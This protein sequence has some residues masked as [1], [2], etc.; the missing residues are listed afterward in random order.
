MQRSIHVPVPKEALYADGVKKGFAVVVMAVLAVAITPALF[1]ADFSTNIFE[2]CPTQTIQTMM[3]TI[4]A[5]E[6]E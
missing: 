4:Y 3:A 1:P 6:C 5:N 2:S